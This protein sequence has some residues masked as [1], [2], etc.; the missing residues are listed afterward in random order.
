MKTKIQVLSVEHKSGRAKSGND[1]AMDVCQCV[2]H[3]VDTVGA[4]LKLP[5]PAR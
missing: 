4:R 1:Y 3:D 2:V 5:I